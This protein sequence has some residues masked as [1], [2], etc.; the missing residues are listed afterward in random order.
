MEPHHILA[1]KGEIAERVIVAGDPGRVKKLAKFLESP[2][3]VNSHRGLLVYTGKYNGVDISVA[4]HGM[5]APSAA[6]IF[7]ELGILGARKF[8]RFGTSGALAPHINIG[9]YVIATSASHPPGGLYAQYFGEDPNHDADADPGLSE[10]LANAFSSRELKFHKGKVFSNDALYAE[11][12][13]FAKK[14]HGAGNIA[15]EMECAILYKL[16]KLRGWKSSSALMVINNVN[17]GSGAW[18]SQKELDRRAAE[19]ARAILDGLSKA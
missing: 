7:E 9:E 17:D 10:H 16:S 12:P 14:H 13:D 4:T 1:K 2:R 11:S 15:V 8:V 5:G 6:I 19:G 3:R 18:A